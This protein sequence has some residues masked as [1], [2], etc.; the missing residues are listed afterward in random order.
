MSNNTNYY[1]KYKKYKALYKI[2]QLKGGCDGE[3]GIPD[4]LTVILNG[5]DGHSITIDDADCNMSVRHLKSR[6]TRSTAI[7][8]RLLSI[9]NAG[10]AD[11]L[12]DN[13]TIS[14]LKDNEDQDTINVF[15]LITTPEQININ[16]MDTLMDLYNSTNGPNWTSNN[17]WDNDA[18][19]LINWHGVITDD[20]G[21]VIG[22]RLR[23]N[24]LSGS[25][26]ESIGN[27]TSLQILH[28]D[29]NQLTGPI[30]ESIGNLTSLTELI[31]S[32]NNL[33][34]PIPD[35]IGN[36]HMLVSLFLSNNQFTG[37]IPDLNTI[38]SGINF[39][40]IY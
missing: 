19:P 30:P 6:I 39:R 35:S 27:L 3:P 23:N 14:E 12:R 37:P 25:I 28:L 9:F 17:N 4:T 40:V 13:Q 26:P 33:T 24:N 8:I 1:K 11:N 10:H 38:R 2:H 29:K 22:L 31:L 16:G 36:L 20:L 7:D 34:D 5:M 32:D 21:F 15:Y 18:I